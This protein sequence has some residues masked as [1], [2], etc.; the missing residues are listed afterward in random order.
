MN[1]V[2]GT[3]AVALATAFAVAVFGGGLATAPTRAG[4]LILPGATTYYVGTGSAGV[5]G[6][7]EQPDFGANGG[8]ATPAFAAAFAA[9]V[10]GD[11]IYVCEGTFYFLT[12]PSTSLAGRTLTIVGAG[13]DKTRLDGNHAQRMLCFFDGGA[14]NLRDLSLVNGGGDDGWGAGAVYGYAVDFNI[15]RVV[16]D[17]NA[18]LDPGKVGLGGALLLDHG[19]ATIDHTIFRH[20]AI[21]YEGGAIWAVNASLD[22]SFSDFIDNTAGYHDGAIGIYAASLLKVRHSTFVDNEA[23]DQYGGAIHAQ[24]ITSVDI[25]ASSFSG[26][27]AHQNGGAV[28]LCAAYRSVIANSLFVDNHA[29]LAGGA[30]GVFC[31]SDL[32]TNIYSNRFLRNSAGT[33]G[34]GVNTGHANNVTMHGNLFDRNTAPR[35]GGATLWTIDG[36]SRAEMAA[37]GG[38]IYTTNTA[39]ISGGGIYLE[40]ATSTARKLLLSGNSFAGN[41]AL[42]AGA[43]RTKEVA[44]G[45][46]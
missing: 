35:G 17:S 27:R 13:A 33:W 36:W 43:S 23:Y 24:N 8:D 20:N 46:C 1:G 38:N 28:D 40:C 2:V 19:S 14:I 4:D 16:F 10:S 44:A 15:R 25:Q 32:S 21:T 6:S 39:T 3:R 41:L 29:D 7:C 12:D 26:N 45:P 22:I 34:G 30:V 37:V 42:G 31:G 11:V 18:A 9:A 5:G